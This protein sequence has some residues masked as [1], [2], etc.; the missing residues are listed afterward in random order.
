[1]SLHIR[2]LSNRFVCAVIPLLTLLLALTGCGEDLPYNGRTTADGWVSIAP[3]NAGFEIEFPAMPTAAELHD[4]GQPAIIGGW[5]FS[6]DQGKRKPYYR[7]EYLD[8]KGDII[9]LLRK[10]SGD[11]TQ[12]LVEAAGKR[13][14]VEVDG[15][16]KS[17]EP[18]SLGENPGI[19]MTFELAGNG[20][21]RA[22]V[23]LVGSRLYRLVVTQRDATPPGSDVER[24][25]NS[26]ALK[27]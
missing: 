6:L 11:A 2:P 26:F 10:A 7:A 18:L 27:S 1:M 21:A 15:R 12:K 4:E 8:Y 14:G 22:R 5:R 3:D 13:L 20:V 23:Y 19:D 24:F 25:F 9:E 16:T 17:E